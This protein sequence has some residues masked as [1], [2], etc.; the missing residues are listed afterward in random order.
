MQRQYCLRGR[1]TLVEAVRKEQ[2][3]Q[4]GLYP[5]PTLLRAS[6][7]E[8]TKRIRSVYKGT[9]RRRRHTF[10]E[11]RALDAS[12]QALSVL[13][14]M[15]LYVP[16]PQLW[17]D[18]FEGVSKGTSNQRG[19]GRKPRIV[20][21]KPRKQ[22]EEP[23]ISIKAV[24]PTE[25][26]TAQAKAEL[27]REDINPKDV[28]KA[29]QTLSGRQRKSTKRKAPVSSKSKKSSAGKRKSKTPRDIFDN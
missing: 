11:T 5:R 9:T 22:T 17:V 4:V 12:F 15:K 28:E 21:I 7:E 24:L 2:Q 3:R 27:E 23:R 13:G 25:Q 20:A 14:I 1:T 19:G 10:S 6:D 8:R 18:Y 29:F 26:A 16:N